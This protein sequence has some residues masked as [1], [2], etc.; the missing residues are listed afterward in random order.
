M[1]A[2]AGV[3]PE[4]TRRLLKEATAAISELIVCCRSLLYGTSIVDAQPRAPAAGA[5]VSG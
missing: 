2:R 3:D 1:V 4:F 5:F